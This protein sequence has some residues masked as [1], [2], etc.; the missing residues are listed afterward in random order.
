MAAAVVLLAIVTYMTVT[1]GNNVVTGIFLACFT[2]LYFF[3]SLRPKQ[4]LILSTAV[5]LVMTFVMKPEVMVQDRNFFGTW[6]V[7]EVKT[8]DD[9]TLRYFTHGSTLHGMAILD[10]DGKLHG[11]SFGYYLHG[12]PIDHVMQITNAKEVGVLGLG[13]GQLACFS[14]T[15]TT[16]FFE[17]DPDIL[18]MAEKYFPYLDKCKPRKVFIGDGRLEIAKSKIKYD[19]IL[20]D[21]FTSDGIPMHLL[22]EEAFADY[23][24]KITPK[25]IILFHISNRYL[26]LAPPLAATAEAVGLQAYM[27]FHHA[28]KDNVKG[29]DSRW[30]AVPMNAQQGAAL[31]K[32]GWKRIETKAQ[33]WTDDK[34]SLISALSLTF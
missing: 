22:T 2:L 26:N 33:P 25:G 12:G 7:A 9:L 20:Q 28:P 1:K 27:I 11:D 29:M 19:V 30:V 13:T 6:R 23:K 10:K 5:F 18:T 31:E 14:K 21:A 32:R 24:T 34:S 16:D 8:K 3:F 4:A 15:A 17:I